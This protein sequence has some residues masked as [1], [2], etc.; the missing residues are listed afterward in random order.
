L[1][2]NENEKIQPRL[3]Q[4]ANPLL[5]IIKNEEVKEGLKA[6]LIEY[7]KQITL[8]RGMTND[9]KIFEALL[10]LLKNY[11]LT[12]IKVK[13]IADVHNKG[14]L[15]AKE[16]LSANKVGWYLRER[17]KIKTERTRDGYVLS[18]SNKA[19]I[20]LLKKKFGI[21]EDNAE[22]KTDNTDGIPVINE[23]TYGK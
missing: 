14:P 2:N 15:D 1:E 5:S 11:L 20:E 21:I 10:T 6:T 18:E 19:R 3:R 4:I 13:D 17:L 16:V 22:I 12:E 9:A 23:E 8:D 7:D